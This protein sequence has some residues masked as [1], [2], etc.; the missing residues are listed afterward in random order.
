MGKWLYRWE[1]EYYTS[2]GFLHTKYVEAKSRDDAL[3]EV[4]KCG[5]RIIEIKCCRRT[6]RY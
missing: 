5:E 4:R 6:D 3:D 2:G 1:V